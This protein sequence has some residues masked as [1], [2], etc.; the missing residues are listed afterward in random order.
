VGPSEQRR[1]AYFLFPLYDTAPFDLYFH[2]F[3]SQGHWATFTA[4][5]AS[6]G[7]LPLALPSSVLLIHCVTGCGPAHL[8]KHAARR[9]SVS[10]L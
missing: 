6:R 4:F 5:H 9:F 1:V 10:S 7:A 3:V 8:A 2:F